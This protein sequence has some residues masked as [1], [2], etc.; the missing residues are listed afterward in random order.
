MSLIIVDIADGKV[1]DRAGDEL[2]T[3]S[4]GSCI[5]VAIYD[6]VVRVGGLI[7]C[8]L[9]LSKVDPQKAVDRP[10]MFVDKGMMLLLGELFKRGLTRKHAIV[11][12]AGCAQILD[13]SNLF[14][15]GERNHTVLRKVLWKNQL[16]IASEAIG[17]SISRTMR[18]HIDTG[19]CTIRSGGKEWEL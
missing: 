13:N 1:S 5:G 15:I 12:I 17:G 10:Y 18:L 2:V 8:M 4:L 16:M 14:R 9:P 19:Y 6:P 7:H 11:K 3:Y